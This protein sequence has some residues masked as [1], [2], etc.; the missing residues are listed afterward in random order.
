M[1]ENVP[2]QLIVAAFNDEKGADEAWKQL[3]SAKWQGIIGIDNM[4][5]IRRDEKNKI[6]IKEAGDPGG[7]KGAA[8]GAVLGGAIGAIAGPLGAVVLGGA[9]GAVVGGITAKYHDAGIPNDRLKQIGEAL[10]PGTS[11]IVALIEHKWVAELE[12][13]LAEEATDVVVAEISADIADQLSQGKDV[14][15]TA[16][17]ADDA[18][19]TAR[20]AGD[21]N[22][23]E[24]SQM[25]ITAEGAS[26]GAM[27]ANEEGMAFAEAT[28]TDDAATY[29][30][31]AV[32]EEGAVVDAIA[33]TDDAVVV[34]E[35]TAT[36]EEGDEG[37]VVEGEVT[38]DSGEDTS[39]GNA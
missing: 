22:S 28:V 19:T 9:T 4:A 24:A 3:K 10:Q 17:A 35:L 26:A 34:G 36:P 30:E 8:I 31:G 32:T 7:G 21:E 11:A 25:T 5:K 12:K 38:E 13:E 27:V 16:V 14:A 15:Y 18:M 2:V 20:V 39:E 6:H 1:S 33:V 37:E 23:V 29:V